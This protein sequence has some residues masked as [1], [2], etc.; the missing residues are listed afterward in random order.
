MNRCAGCHWCEPH[1]QG[2]QQP[3]PRSNWWRCSVAGFESAVRGGC[4]NRGDARNDVQNL[5]QTSTAGNRIKNCVR[6]AIA[7]HRDEIRPGT[8]GIGRPLQVVGILRVRGPAQL[9][10]GLN[11]E[12][13]LSVGQATPI[14]STRI[15]AD[16][17]P[18]VLHEQL[19]HCGC[20]NRHTQTAVV[21]FEIYYSGKG[22]K[23][24]WASL[25]NRY[26]LRLAV[27]RL[28]AATNHQG[29]KQ[30]QTNQR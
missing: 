28:T 26:R 22:R 21:H 19:D 9:N 15:P 30:S 23:P 1:T 7:C 13:H 18:R 4:G 3:Y 14:T 20:F 6:R 27:L 5:V 29:T 10:T 8:N 24:R 2:R 17:R 25:P 12:L 11:V 16:A